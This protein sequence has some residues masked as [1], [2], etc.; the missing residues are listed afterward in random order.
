M[1]SCRV[2]SAAAFRAAAGYHREDGDDGQSNLNKSVFISI[3]LN[4]LTDPTVYGL[5]LDQGKDSIEHVQEA[6]SD[7]LGHSMRDLPVVGLSDAARDAGQRVGISSQRDGFPD[8]VFKAGR[9]QEGDD[10][11]RYGTLTAFVPT[12]DKC[13]CIVTPIVGQL[14]TVFRSSIKHI[15]SGV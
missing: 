14:R 13:R 1:T 15:G 9:F 12:V 11:L 4:D 7:S 6:G 2:E 10:C 3:L 8:G 5:F